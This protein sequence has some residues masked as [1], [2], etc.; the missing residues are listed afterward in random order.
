IGDP[1]SEKL[2][3]EACLQLVEEGL[4]RG[5]QDLGGAGLTC[6]VSESAARARLGADL[7]LDQVPLRERSME[8][9]EI[10]TSESQERMLAIVR[11]DDVEAVQKICERWGLPATP[12]AKLRGGGQ[13]FVQHEGGTVARV[14][15]RALA[16]QGPVYERRMSRPSWP[17]RLRG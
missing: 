12:V 17:E 5:L 7:D 10:L 2:L 16:D 1:F 4:L 11:P 14:P 9:F 6:A 13:L 8:A 15:A 3:V